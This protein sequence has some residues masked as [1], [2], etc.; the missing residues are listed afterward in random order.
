MYTCIICR[1]QVSFDDTVAP[2]D[3]GRC[4][5]LGCYLRNTDDQRRPDKKLTRE[6]ESVLAAA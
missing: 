4:I 6:I 1:F 2:T 5:C 3:S